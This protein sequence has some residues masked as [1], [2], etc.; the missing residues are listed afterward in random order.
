MIGKYYIVFEKNLLMLN[1]GVER[2]K[3]EDE[4]KARLPKK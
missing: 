1:S 3:K 2:K 4:K